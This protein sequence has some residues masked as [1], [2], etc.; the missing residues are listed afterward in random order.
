MYARSFQGEIAKRLKQCNPRAEVE[1]IPNKMKSHEQKLS[2]DISVQ[3]RSAHWSAR[4]R[5]IDGIVI[6]WSASHNK[7]KWAF[8]DCSLP[9]TANRAGSDEEDGSEEVWADDKSESFQ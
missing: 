9:I 2:I 1:V 5:L 6:A 7:G 4:N 8:A 3:Q